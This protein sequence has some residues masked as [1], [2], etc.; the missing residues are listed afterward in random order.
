M[1]WKPFLTSFGVLAFLWITFISS[2]TQ[3]VWNSIDVAIF[4]YLNGT[5]EG[6]KFL[7][8][9]WATI[10]HKRM[11]LVEDIVF[12]VFF[13]WGIKAAPKDQKWKRASQ[14]IFTILLAGCVI[15]FINRNLLRY[16]VLIPR[17]SPSLV[18]SPCVKITDEID[19]T[20]LKDETI[21]SFPGDHATTLLL[22]GFL[23]SA[24]VPRRLATVA[25]LYVAFRILPRLVVGAHWFSDVAVG[26][27]TI[28]LFFT[29]CFL[30]TPLGT[31]I[32]QALEKLNPRRACNVTQKDSL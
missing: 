31:L 14:F 21:A 22:F 20:G 2:W 8:Y 27:V 19:W 32:I 18:V 25:W 5:L 16:N 17:E 26:S 4:K 12:L 24:F 11:D 15:L 3:P 13:I 23:F 28:A 1:K 6:N 7:Q 10:N 29:A 9:F 30:Y